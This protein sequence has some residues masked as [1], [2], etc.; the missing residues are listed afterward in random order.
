MDEDEDVSVVDEADVVIFEQNDKAVV[1]AEENDENVSAVM[2]TYDAKKNTL[3][4]TYIW[5]L[6]LLNRIIPVGRFGE[7]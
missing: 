7:N 2:V 1:E 4:G 5:T 6:L 3:E